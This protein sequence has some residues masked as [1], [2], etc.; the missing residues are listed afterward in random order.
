MTFS[1]LERYSIVEIEGKKV[2]TLMLQTSDG[3]AELSFLVEDRR[4]KYL[5]N[6]LSDLFQ[7]FQGVNFID[8]LI[9]QS[10]YLLLLQRLSESNE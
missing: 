7:F 3:C 6:N 5:F 1:F 8:K 9:D 4:G 10:E 2:S